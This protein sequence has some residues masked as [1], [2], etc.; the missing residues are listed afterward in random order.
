MSEQEGTQSG[1]YSP[2]N[3]LGR[4]WGNVAIR[5]PRAR[6]F[7]FAQAVRIS[8]APDRYPGKTET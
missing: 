8:R 1:Q 3:I 7:L 2:C 4:F 5:G 6:H